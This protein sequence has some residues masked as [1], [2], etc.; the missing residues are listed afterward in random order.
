MKMKT[1]TILIILFLAAG[2]ILISCSKTN[3]S[4]AVRSDA[5]GTEMKPGNKQEN[6]AVPSPYTEEYKDRQSRKYSKQ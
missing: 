6:T 1:R 4:A 5:S 2:S 3:F